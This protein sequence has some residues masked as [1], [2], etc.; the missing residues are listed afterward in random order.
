MPEG[1]CNTL[2]EDSMDTIYWLMAG[3]AVVWVGL[4]AYLAFLARRERAL[5]L[6]LD[7]RERGAR[8]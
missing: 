8:G 3:N 5:A 1:G 6:R 4:G 7:A 2:T